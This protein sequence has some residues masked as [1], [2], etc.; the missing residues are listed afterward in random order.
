MVQVFSTALAEVHRFPRSCS[1]SST[2]STPRIRF[3]RVFW[4]REQVLV[5][6][7]LVGSRHRP[8]GVRQR[9]TRAV[10]TITD[11]VGADA[12]RGRFG[13]RTTFADEKE[14]DAPPEG[15]RALTGL[16]L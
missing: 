8:R 4:V 11:H 3:A 1:R 9:L 14:A 12:R 2:G 10:A 15:D 16:Y 6:T 7:E 13:G 5:E